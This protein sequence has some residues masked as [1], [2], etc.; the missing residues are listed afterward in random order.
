[1]Q[2]DQ[3]QEKCEAELKKRKEQLVEVLDTIEDDKQLIIKSKQKSLY[4]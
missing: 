1:M 3:E 4:L 2:I